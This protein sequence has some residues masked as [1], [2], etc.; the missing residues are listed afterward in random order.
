MTVTLNQ[1]LIW[2]TVSIGRATLLQFAKNALGHNEDTPDGPVDE[3]DDNAD[4]DE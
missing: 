1:D 4:A 2:N 3:W